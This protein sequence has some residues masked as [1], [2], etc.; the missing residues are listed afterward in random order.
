MLNRVL[1]I[2]ALVSLSAGPLVAQQ[3]MPQPTPPAPRPAATRNPAAPPQPT[4]I[5]LD[6]TITDQS[7]PG[8]A[9][10]KTVSM[11]L[12]DQQRGSIRNRGQLFIEGKGRFEVIL[13]VDAT[14]VI[15]PD[16]TIRLT[17]ALEYAPKPDADNAGTGEGRGHLNESLGLMIVPGKPLTISQSS[18]PTSDRRIA[19][20]L[21][22]SILK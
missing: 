1:T 4:N 5:K 13:N 15:L 8:Q 3:A 2:V 20:E 6:L 14:P 19:V 22:A 7:G 10:R 11:I 12:A 17:L 18:D 21:V 16:N 9:A